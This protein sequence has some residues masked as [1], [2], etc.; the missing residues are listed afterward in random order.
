MPLLRSTLSVPADESNRRF[1]DHRSATGNGLGVI[2]L[3]ARMRHSLNV[4]V[5]L[6]PELKSVFDLIADHGGVGSSLAHR[7][8]SLPEYSREDQESPRMTSS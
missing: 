5:I 7:E 1:A 4:P 8:H 2:F 6:T 3:P